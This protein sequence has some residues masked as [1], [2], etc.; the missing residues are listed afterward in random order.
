MTN[1]AN[2]LKVSKQTCLWMKSQISFDFVLWRSV[3]DRKQ[4]HNVLYFDPV[5]SES[6]NAKSVMI[7]PLPECKNECFC[8]SGIYFDDF[9]Q[10]ND[11]FLSH[12]RHVRKPSK[13]THK[14]FPKI[15]VVVF[16][17]KSTAWNSTNFIKTFHKMLNNR[18]GYY[19]NITFHHLRRVKLKYMNKE[20][21][22]IVG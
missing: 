1:A 21:T 18:L 3:E 4:D 17:E 9:T 16:S 7:V 5:H 13:L 19:G 8:G 12:I 11:L 10:C 20:V 22:A 15:I 2:T 14:W 6:E